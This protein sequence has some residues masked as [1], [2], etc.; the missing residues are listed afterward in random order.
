MVKVKVMT[1]IQSGNAWVKA[2]NPTKKERYK[3]LH[4]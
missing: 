4:E 2:I 1:K 3:L